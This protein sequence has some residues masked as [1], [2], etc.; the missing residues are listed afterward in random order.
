[1]ATKRNKTPPV[2]QGTPPSRRES[3]SATVKQKGHA[4]VSPAMAEALSDCEM[5]F[6]INLPQSEL[7]TSDRL[8]FQI[9]QV[10]NHT[11]LRHCVA[12]MEADGGSGGGGGGGVVLV[13][14]ARLIGVPPLGKRNGHCPRPPPRARAHSHVACPA[15]SPCTSLDRRTG[16]TRTSLRTRTSRAF[17]T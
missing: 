3:P 9:E 4:M 15:C 2:R 14:G 6:I 8:F 5:K 13:E 1:M 7:Q 10:R 17:R 11:G 12:A 16:T